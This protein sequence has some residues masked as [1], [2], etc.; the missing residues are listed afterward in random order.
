MSI[1][2]NLKTM[3]LASAAVMAAASAQAQSTYSGYF[4]DNYL[5]R[6][7]MNPA[8]G[9]ESNFVG[10]PALGNLNVG[11]EGNLHL[12][13]IFHNVDGRTTLFTNPGVSVNEVMGGIH[14]KNRLGADLK[15]NIDRKSVV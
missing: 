14:D 12:T 9:N 13:N 11:M 1:M 8:F 7:E 6:S 15:L 10:F 4:L 3:I 5:Y 2:K